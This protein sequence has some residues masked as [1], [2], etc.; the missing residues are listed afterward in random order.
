MFLC[1]IFDIYIFV[2]YA[3]YFTKFYSLESTFDNLRT[4]GV[5]K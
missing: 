3:D 5:D 2:M 1:C 4:K